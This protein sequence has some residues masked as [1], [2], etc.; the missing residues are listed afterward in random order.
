[1]R[2]API[3]AVHPSPTTSTTTTTTQPPLPVTPVQ[4]TT[5]G[6][7]QCGSVTVPLDYARPDGPTLQIAVARH[8][9]DDPS[10]RIGSLVINP[11]GPGTSGI[12]DLPNELSVLTPGLLDH[13]DIVSFDPRGVER[14]SPVTCT[15][16]GSGSGGSGGGGSGQLIDPVPTT[17]AAQQD[18]LQNDQEFAAQ[19]Q[20]SSGV[21]LPYVDTADTARDLDRIRAAL[22]DAQ[23]TFIGHSYGTLLGAT[24]A[25][26]FPTKVRAMVL[27]G[28]IDPALSTVQYATEQA[29]SYESDLQAFFSWC[30]A[31]PGC[32]WHP[33]GRPDHGAP[34][35][36]PTEQDPSPVGIRGRIGGTRRA[37]RLAAGRARVP[38]VVAVAG[39]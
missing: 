7:L 18:L 25:E 35:P 5:C 6:D 14:S 27:D 32:A 4:W 15:G 28:A 11:G 39:R 13:F 9:A 36:H 24:Y 21:I 17:P 1:M 38:L 22:G 3:G 34:R 2:T 19:C 20:R 12:D 23:L 16:G 30:A 8:P 29:D 31:D 33:V 10:E 37:V 26:L